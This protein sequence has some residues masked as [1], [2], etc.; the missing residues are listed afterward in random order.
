MVKKVPL[1]RLRQI[2]KTRRAPMLVDQQPHTEENR[3]VRALR[4][5]TEESA[6]D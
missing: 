5:E 3:P 6:E 2:S 1:H 4:R